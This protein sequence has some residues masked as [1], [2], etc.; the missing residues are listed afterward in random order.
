VR[1]VLT[2]FIK[3]P[4][5]I[6]Q[7]F[8]D[9]A[10][11]LT[12]MGHEV[13]T[14]IRSDMPMS[15]RKYTRRHCKRMYFFN[16]KGYYDVI[17][18][19][20]I[21]FVLKRIKP[22][23]IISH[24]NRSSSLA[25]KAVKG[26][27]IPT[28]GVS[29]SYN[30]KR[31]IGMDGVIALTPHMQS[32]IIKQKQPA[33]KVFIV[34]NMISLS[35]NLPVKIQSE[36]LDKILTIGIMSHIGKH[37]GINHLIKSIYSLGKKGIICNLL[38]AGDGEERLQLEKMVQDMSLSQQV[39]FLGWIQHKDSFFDQIDIF[40]LPSLSE[41]FGIVILEAFSH[42]IPVVATS[43]DGPNYLIKN[44]KNGLLCDIASHHSLSEALI[45]VVTDIQLW[46]KLS[47]AGYESVQRF[48]SMRVGK[49]LEKILLRI[50]Q[51]YKGTR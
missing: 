26:L 49:K 51:N 1:I 15:F 5:G 14:L 27:N 44:K 40:C 38:I 23:I 16:P 36:P 12:D 46:K 18:F 42:G 30:V 37:K 50:I 2:T 48:D 4:G 33:D 8:M 32:H 35:K 9:Y 22:D 13:H 21:R 24:G 3:A 43:C 6:A 20:R 31:S 29:H 19:F 28:V 39:K 7:S 17:T 47:Q 45:E 34:P 11:V 10:T 25:K 41:T